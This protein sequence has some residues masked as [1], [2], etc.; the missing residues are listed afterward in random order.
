MD[1]KQVAGELVRIAKGLVSEELDA[2]KLTPEFNSRGLE[3]E[4]K[5]RAG[6]DPKLDF[7]IKPGRRGPYVAINS[8]NLVDSSGVF[9]EVFTDVRISNFG[10]SIGEKDGKIIAWIPVHIDWK[11]KGGGTNGAEWFTAWFDFGTKKWTFR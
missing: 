1:E 10:G 7:E 2:G 6:I 4:I 11:H 3:S 5:K 8:K 9:K